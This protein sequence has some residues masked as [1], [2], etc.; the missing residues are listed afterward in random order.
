MSFRTWNG[1][2]FRFHLSDWG[3][4]STRV[5]FYGFRGNNFGL[6]ASRSHA[7]DG[8]SDFGPGLELR[9]SCA[10]RSLRRRTQCES[11]SNLQ[12]C[13]RKVASKAVDGTRALDSVPGV[14]P[15]APGPALTIGRSRQEQ[16]FRTGPVS[17]NAVCRPPA[18]LTSESPVKATGPMIS[19]DAIRPNS[20]VA[21]QGVRVRSYARPQTLGSPCIAAPRREVQ[22]QA[23]KSA[24]AES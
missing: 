18:R 5:F 21:K 3:V 13:K 9:T 4:L 14:A 22:Q 19:A 12:W 2:S 8:P 24:M 23:V 20:Q 16:N 11:A 7:R 10:I 17:G 6:L 1:N 15:R